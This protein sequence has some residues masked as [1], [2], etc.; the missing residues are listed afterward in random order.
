MSALKT[1]L[2]T[3]WAPGRAL[4]EAADGRLFFW[5]LLI[6]TVVGLGYTALFIPRADLAAIAEKQLDQLPAEE[7]GKMTP[8]EREEKIESVGKLAVISSYGSAALAP[9]FSTLV[10][11][12]CFWLGF[13]V[14]GGKPTFM[15]SFAV[16]AHTQLPGA[17]QALLSI[18]ALVQREKMG[19]DE[20]FRLLPSN[21]A[22]LAPEGTSLPHLSLLSSVD[23]FAAWALVLTVMGMAHVSKVSLLR[24][25]VVSTILWVSFVL[26]FRFALPSLTSP[27]PS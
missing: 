5:P 18:P 9:A 23:L 16:V 26:V 20:V 3:L 7:A 13:K 10:A 2:A 8:H 14:A 19:L 25:S 1:A 21:L 27:G 17:I 22:A 15:G 11:A 4:K 12:L 6:A 24:S